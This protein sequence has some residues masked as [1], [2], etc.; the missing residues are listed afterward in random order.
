[1][2]SL[3]LAKISEFEI[4]S[5]VNANDIDENGNER[6]AR[7]ACNPCK[8]DLS[9]RQLTIKEVIPFPRF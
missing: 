3:F 1:M 8:D 2:G 5:H 7:K 6:T 4:E 9:D